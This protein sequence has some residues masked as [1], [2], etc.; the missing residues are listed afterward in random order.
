LLSGAKPS[1]CTAASHRTGRQNLLIF[2]S[3]ARGPRLFAA[4]AVAC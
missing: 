2:S 3:Q 4:I 1:L